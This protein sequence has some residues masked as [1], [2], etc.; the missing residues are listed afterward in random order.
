MAPAPLWELVKFGVEHVEIPSKATCIAM[1]NGPSVG[2]L[3]IEHGRF[4][5]AL[6]HRFPEGIKFFKV[7]TKPT[8]V[9]NVID[10]RK[11]T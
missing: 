6:A 2:D 1:D 3:P 10:T 8:S 9:F 5:I 7:S 4:S 11:D